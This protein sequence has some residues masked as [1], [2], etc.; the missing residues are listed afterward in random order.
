MLWCWPSHWRPDMN[1][2]FRLPRVYGLAL[3]VSLRLAAAAAPPDVG[4]PPPDAIR[5]AS[6]LVMT[7]LQAGTG[8]DHPRGDDC[9][10]VRFTG[11]KRDG[12]LFSTSGLHGETST[13]CL[14]AAI[15]GI[16]E[17]LSAMAPGEKRRIWVPADLAFAAHMAHHGVKLMPENPPPQVDLTFDVELVRILK[18][19]Q[20]PPDLKTPPADAF[21]TPSGIAI[22]VLKPGTGAKHPSPSS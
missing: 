1:S 16:A 14:T 6:G 11:W 3:S 7:V 12:A 17:A 4:A 9:A 15:P 2:T 10:I 8:T 22:L 5:T 18:A 13:Q 19:A 21:R 20:K